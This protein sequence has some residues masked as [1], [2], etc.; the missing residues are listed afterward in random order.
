MADEE[1]ARLREL[2]RKADE[3]TDSPPP[4]GPSR[5]PAL[6]RAEEEA[7]L[8]KLNEGSN[9]SKRKPSTLTMGDLDRLVEERKAP[10]AHR[11]DFIES[12]LKKTDY[13]K[14]Y[15][16]FNREDQL[17]SRYFISAPVTS[18]GYSNWLFAEPLADDPST[19][20]RDDGMI[21]LLKK[22][23]R[24]GIATWGPKKSA[25]VRRGDDTF[26]EKMSWLEYLEKQVQHEEDVW[27]LT[28]PI[29]VKQSDRDAESMRKKP[30]KG[31]H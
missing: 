18:G 31:L 27:G 11:P 1:E 7:H 30:R 13:Q 9:R 23:W 26:P 20:S 14:K 29:Y 21:G 12:E 22:R 8:R 17:I 16:K 5:I 25:L 19:A 4:S 24:E 10:F 3:A 15:E 28:Q 6:L 2:A